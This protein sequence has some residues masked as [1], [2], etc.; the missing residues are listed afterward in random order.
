MKLSISISSCLAVSLVASLAIVGVAVD[1]LESE[2]IKQR[3][4]AEGVTAAAA[5]AAAYEQILAL[6][7]TSKQ[8]SAE[9]LLRPNYIPIKWPGDIKVTPPRYRVGWDTWTDASGIAQIQDAIKT[10]GAFSYA[11]GMNLDGYVPTPHAAYNEPPVGDLP[12]TDMATAASAAMGIPEKCGHDALH[13]RQKQKYLGQE[14]LQAARSETAGWLPYT[15]NTGQEAIDV[16]SPI[17]VGGQ[18]WGS[19]RVGVL[20]DEVDAHHR[21]LTIGLLFLLGACSLALVAVLYVV[22]DWKLAPLTLLARQAADL[23]Q[24]SDPDVLRTPITA[25]SK[26]EVGDMAR[27]INLLR[28][29]LQSAMSRIG[30][31]EDYNDMSVVYDRVPKATK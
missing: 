7:V 28:K 22:T 17:S 1:R 5:G 14:Q 11:S 30:E 12:C 6:G 18:H 8:L 26:N 23:S 21:A 24:T 29:S 2:Q 16:F 10:A 27:S 20:L 9:E 13:S 25:T 15:R 19:F 4:I 3:L 31:G